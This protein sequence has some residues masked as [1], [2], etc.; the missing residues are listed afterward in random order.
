MAQPA[1]P[2]RGHEIHLSATIGIAVADR[3]DVDPD[4]L[5]REAGQAMYA[6][7]SDGKARYRFAQPPQGEPAE[8]SYTGDT[9][10]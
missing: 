2:G 5:L 9:T 6:A 7:K 4:V 10:A 3:P 8:A 1:V